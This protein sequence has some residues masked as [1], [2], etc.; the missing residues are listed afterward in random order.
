[1][2]ASEHSRWNDT[3][4]GFRSVSTVIA[5]DHRL[6]GDAQGRGPARAAAGR[7]D[8]SCQAATN[9]ATAIAAS[10]K[11]SI[12]LPNSIASWTSELAV[13]GERLVGAARPGRAAEAGAGQPDRA[14]GHHEADVGDQRRPARG[15]A[16]PL[17]RRAG[18]LPP[19]R[20]RG[21]HACRRRPRRAAR[22]GRARLNAARSSASR[23]ASPSAPDGSQRGHVA[24]PAVRRRGEHHGAAGEQQQVDEVGGGQRRL[25]AQRSGQQQ[26]ER[27]ERGGAEQHGGAARPTHGSGR[28]PS[29][30]QRRPRRSRRSCI[31]STSQQRADLAG[32][33]PSRGR[34]GRRRAA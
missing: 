32:S 9:V 12:R 11:V 15:G 7:G 29:P 16:G 3:T 1:M 23:S 33:S 27:G 14:A 25:G 18:S 22:P 17:P 34:A 31:A 6:G 10:T 28:G 13:R 20:P 2:I 19:E 24:E 21:Q 5:A 26:A 8:R 30:G 4:H